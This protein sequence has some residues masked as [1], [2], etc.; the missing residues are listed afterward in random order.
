MQ[1]VT[2]RVDSVIAA[3]GG[4][5]RKVLAL[6]LSIAADKRVEKVTGLALQIPV[7]CL[8]KVRKLIAGGRGIRLRRY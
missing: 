8:R 2:A 6:H 1:K 3:I 7:K 5:K 4:G